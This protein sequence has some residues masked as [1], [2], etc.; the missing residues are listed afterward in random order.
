MRDGNSIGLYGTGIYPED[1]CLFLVTWI[2]LLCLL[3]TV[4]KLQ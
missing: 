2:N 1:T 3:G 4:D